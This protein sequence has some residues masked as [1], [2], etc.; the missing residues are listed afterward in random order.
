MWRIALAFVVLLAACGKDSGSTVSDILQGVEITSKVGRILVESDTLIV[1]DVLSVEGNEDPSIT[2]YTCG[3]QSCDS[4]SETKPLFAPPSSLDKLSVDTDIEYTE[5]SEL[6]GVDLARYSVTSTN[7]VGEWTF[8]HY[9]AWLDHSAFETTIGSATTTDEIDLSTAYSLSFG[10]ATGK[11][12]AGDGMWEGVMLGNTR[13]RSIE[14]L[15]GN[16]TVSFTFETGELDVKFTD[17]MNLETNSLHADI[18][19]WPAISVN[20]DGEF[21]WRS[22]ADGVGHIAGRFYGPDHAEVGGVFTWPTALGA[23]GAKK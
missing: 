12:P 14:P 3:G 19:K 5:I 7:D 9:G 23:F 8:T 1:S 17:I 13:N 2:E 21:E 16:A 4:V 6:K 15:R 10:D 20:E 11:S 22:V 18:I